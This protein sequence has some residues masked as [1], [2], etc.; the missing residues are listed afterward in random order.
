MRAV[1]LTCTKWNTLSNSKIFTEMHIDNAFAPAQEDDDSES[2]MIVTTEEKLY[3]MS[4]LVNNNV[5]LSV[6]EKGKLTCLEEQVKISNVYHCEGLLLCILKDD[7]TKVVVWN[8]YTG[9]TRWIELRYPH[10]LSCPKRFSCGWEGFSYGI[11]YEDKGSCR[12]YKI[13]RERDEHDYGWGEHD[14]IIC[15]DYTRERFGPLLPLPYGDCVRILSSVREEKLAVEFNYKNGY[16]IWM[17]TMIEAEKVSWSNFYKEDYVLHIDDDGDDDDDDDDDDEYSVPSYIRVRVPF[18]GFC[19]DQREKMAIFS[20][21][22][23]CH[24]VGEVD[25]KEHRRKCVCCYVPSLVKIKQ[26]KGSQRERKQSDLEKL[27]YDEMMWRLSYFERRCKRLDLEL[28]K[29]EASTCKQIS[30]PRSVVP[31]QARSIS[32]L[33]TNSFASLAS[34]DDEE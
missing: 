1:R 23:K 27:R 7:D 3:L 28:A 32:F 12:N 11:G 19:I 13:L 4:V 30:Y 5:D 6:E 14:H 18:G 21:G 20:F 22:L 10:V 29:K 26:P 8:P 33:S 17:T 2:H 34:S 9:Q 16:S 31:E 15:F 24:M 25:L